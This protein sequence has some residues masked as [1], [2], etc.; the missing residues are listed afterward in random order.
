MIGVELLSH[1]MNLLRSA[2]RPEIVGLTLANG[3]VV[4]WSRYVSWL[5]TCPALL[6]FLVSMVSECSTRV[7][8]RPVP[9]LV[10]NQV[11]LLM[12]ASAAATDNVATN[13]FSTSSPP[14]VQAS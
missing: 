3:R 9:L 14:H 1:S 7:R 12:A 6:M 11:M 5:S 8:I 4:P 2:D 10:N 13:G